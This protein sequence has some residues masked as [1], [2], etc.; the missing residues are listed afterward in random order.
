M[1]GGCGHFNAP[2]SAAQ[3]FISGCNTLDV[4][5]SGTFEIG[6]IEA[7]CS[8]PQVLRVP[9]KAMAQYGPLYVYL[10]YRR[11]S[12]SVASDSKSPKGVY[13]HASAEYGGDHTDIFFDAGHD[14]DYALD[15]FYIHDPL[16]TVDST[17]T[18]PSSGA[19]FK[20]TA[21]GDTAT[22]D[23]TIP[24]ARPARPSASTVRRPQRS[25]CA[26]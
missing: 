2:E 8:G 23:V 13:F 26:R 15:P 4:A 18:E 17:W 25:M 7:K 11:G 16:A 6:P 20:L 22:V 3:G 19:T 14:Y 9:A 5:S 24:G 10:E 1:G 21:I 12:G